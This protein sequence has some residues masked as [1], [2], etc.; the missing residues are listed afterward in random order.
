MTTIP[1]GITDPDP[2]CSDPDNTELSDLPP[3]PP[4]PCFCLESKHPD[5]AITF[6]NND[7]A[8]VDVPGHICQYHQLDL[9]QLEEHVYHSLHENSK[10]LG[11][12]EQFMVDTA[13]R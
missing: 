9:S 13:K 1:G 11:V 7:Y 6:S 5:S 10:P 8:D 3:P 12:K 2:C 4:D